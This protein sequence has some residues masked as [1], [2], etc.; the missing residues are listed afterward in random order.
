[1]IIADDEFVKIG[2]I[3]LPGIFKSIEIDGSAIIE[4]LEVEGKGKKPKQATGYE[5]HT[6]TIEL[7]LYDDIDS[8][9]KTKEEKLEIIQNIFRKRDQ[10]IPNVY[11]IVNKHAHQRGISRVIFKK[12]GTKESSKNN[13]VSVSI[14]LVE[15]EPISVTATSKSNK[16]SKSDESSNASV[17]DE[18]KQYLVSDRGHAPKLNSKTSSSPANNIPSPKE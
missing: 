4:E 15:Y 2:G 18:Y 3:L 17:G 7:L 16:T 14:T 8:N 6:I 13:Q 10:R 12:L 9:G 1:M 5:D 11:N